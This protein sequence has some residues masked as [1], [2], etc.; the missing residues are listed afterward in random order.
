MNEFKVSPAKVQWLATGYMLINGI[1]I[2]A[3][4]FFIQRFTNRGIF[5]TAMGL[6]TAGTLLASI[7]PSFGILL[8]ARMIQ[9]AGSAIMMPLLMNVMLVAFS[10]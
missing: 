5:L 3:S 8:T 7:S 6:F 2:P 4:A 1:L 10:N 9:A